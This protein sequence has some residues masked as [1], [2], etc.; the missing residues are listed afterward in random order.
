VNGGWT[1]TRFDQMN[2]FNSLGAS[3]TTG[4]PEHTYKGWFIGSGFEYNFTWLPIPGLF[5][6][7]EYRYSTYQKDDIAEV[8]FA[9]GGS[10]GNFG[11]GNVLH[12]SKQVQT[13]TTSLVW[14]F[15]GFH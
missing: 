15:N 13:V 1:E 2:I 11:F 9:T 6:R 3:S 12:A 7:T 14:R 5:L 10:T 4:F 8:D